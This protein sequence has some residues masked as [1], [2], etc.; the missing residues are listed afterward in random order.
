M[1]PLLVRTV[2]L[3]SPLVILS[4]LLLGSCGD[5]GGGTPPPT[6]T[7]SVAL[8]SSTLTLTQGQNN[9]VTVSVTRGGGY[10]GA[11]DLSLEGAPDGVSGTFEPASIPSG[12]TTSTLTLTA[13]M[14][15]AA[16]A[17]NLTVRARGQGVQEKTA[18]LA[19]TVQEAPRIALS[20]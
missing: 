7:I 14:A 6:P 18:A 8:G 2:R 20:A 11:V 1:R 17:H 9:T 12:S 4:T 3:A 10:S 19:L 16:G 5:G 15:A 13:T